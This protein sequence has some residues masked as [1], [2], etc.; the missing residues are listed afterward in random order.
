VVRSR[1]VGGEDLLEK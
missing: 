1:L